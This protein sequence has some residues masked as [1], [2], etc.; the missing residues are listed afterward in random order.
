MFRA[1]KP[2]NVSLGKK[3]GGERE[4]LWLY[5]AVPRGQK[6]RYGIGS[7]RRRYVC[8]LLKSALFCAEPVVG[9]KMRGR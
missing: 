5:K 1:K 7:E 3:R 9:K 4:A 6:D 8:L 2:K